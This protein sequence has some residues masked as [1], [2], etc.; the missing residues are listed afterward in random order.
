[1]IHTLEVSGVVAD[2]QFAKISPECAEFWAKIKKIGDN[3][4]PDA[5]V[6]GGMV[7]DKYRYAMIS[8]KEWAD[9]LSELRLILARSKT[10]N[11]S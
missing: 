2:F 1:M 9:L 3:K 10:G 8:E 11:L 7:V 6:P 5:L 4:F